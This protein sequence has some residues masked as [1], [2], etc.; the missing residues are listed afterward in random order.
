M[1]LELMTGLLLDARRRNYAVCYCEAWN[2]E[3]FEG[4]LEAA[5]ETDS[6]IIAGFNGGFLM[7]PQ[8]IKPENLALYAGLGHA[9]AAVSVPV[10]FLLNETDDLA[11]IRYGIELGFN[12]VMVESDHLG[13][14]EY[15]KV[16]KEAVRIAHSRGVSV[17]AQVGR[18]PY[19][20]DRG[21][22]QGEMTDPSV[23]KRFVQ[24][25]EV[26]ALGISIGN[27]H[28][29][30]KGHASIDLE[31]LARIH[32]L[33]EIPLVIHG[34]TGFPMQLAAEAI[35]FGV[36]KF[37]FG[38][39]LKQAYLQAIDKALKDYSAGSDPH[40]FLGIGGKKDIMVAGKEAVKKK[41]KELLAATGSAGKAAPRGREN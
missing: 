33:I 9:L 13:S 6:P 19:L 10:A 15:L 12:A 7:H 20:G 36:A 3:S 2:I 26:D 38:T 37:N 17:E 21:E 30:T 29:L 28:V 16:V 35:R 31:S 22:L 32:E 4:V 23:A 5:E 41:V 11:Q 25:T 34:G 24:E 27:V 14:A 39:A 1:P 8:R 40:P 18:L